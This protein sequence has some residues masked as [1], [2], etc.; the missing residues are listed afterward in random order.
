MLPCCVDLFDLLRRVYPFRVLREA[1][2]VPVGDEVAEL[3]FSPGQDIFAQNDGS[4]DVY[5]LVEGRVDVIDRRSGRE[6][7]A[8]TIEA[9]HYFGEWEALFD[10][11]R[12]FGIRAAVAGRC[13]VMSGAFFRRLVT[14][15]PALA[16]GFGTILRDHHGIFAA[17]D[18][19]KGQLLAGADHG[20]LDIARLVDLY[21]DLEPALHAGVQEPHR[22][23]TEALGYALRRLPANVTST[24]AYLLV[25]EVPPAFG[26]PSAM[27]AQVASAARRRDVWEMLPGKNLVLL[28]TGNSDLIDLVTCLC[29]FAVEARKI[30]ERINRGGGLVVLQHGVV[31]GGDDVS[32]GATNAL[33]DSLPFSRREMEG[34]RRIWG[35]ATLSRLFDI[36]RHREM[37]AVEVLRRQ[38]NYALRRAEVWAEEVA[39]LT[40]DLLG[41]DPADLKPGTRVHIISSNTH[42]VTNCLNPWFA[43]NRDRIVDWAR[44]TGHPA[45]ALEWTTLSDLAY[46]T[47]RDYHA[48]V[49]EARA[50][51]LAVASGHGQVRLDRTASTGIQVQLI[52]LARLRGVAIDQ[53]VVQISAAP[54]DGHDVIVNIDYAFG[55]QAEQVMRVLLMLFGSNVASVNFLGKA[56]ALLGRRGD[57]LVPTAFIEQHS[58]LF[59]PL[60]ERASRCSD[61]SPAAEALVRRLPGADVHQGPMLTVDGTLLQNRA[62]LHFYRRIWGVVGMEMEGTHYY[63]EILESAELGVIRGDVAYRFFYYVSDVPLGGGDSLVAPLSAAEGVPPLY[64]ITRHILDEILKGC[65]A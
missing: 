10:D 49:P 24:F 31:Q 47:V 11:R 9:P 19:F 4:D 44:S 38:R 61:G 36:A 53:D 34:L 15:S 46:A 48:A 62:M 35:G 64:A 7:I 43:A 55:E 40:R 32:G 56:G 27:F 2:R 57:I 16:K 5:L 39:R 8:S 42:S 1:H 41:C 45:A 6:E 20:R 52:D 30:R 12:V 22:L 50:E 60:P 29:L 18:R 37:F 59:Q 26:N 33:F 25:D 13:L 63:R 14:E 51:S 21:R 65:N 58:D 54:I 28:R 3:A 23:D 17:F